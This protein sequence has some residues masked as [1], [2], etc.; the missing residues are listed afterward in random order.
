MLKSVLVALDESP[1]SEAARVFAIDMCKRFNARL[2]GVGIVDKPSITAAEPVPL[3]ASRFKV[4]RDEE[5]LIDADKR[6][7]KLLKKFQSNCQSDGVPAETLEIVGSAAECIV[8]Q[9]HRCDIVVMG[10]ETHFRFETQDE[11]DP[12]LGQ[13]LRSSPRLSWRF[14]ELR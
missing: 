1:W 7:R 8:R 6:V 10:R 13:V 14:P 4:E 11:P 3:G 5:K 12:T 9:A 2:L